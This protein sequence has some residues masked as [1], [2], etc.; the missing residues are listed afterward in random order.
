[1]LGLLQGWLAGVG[2]DATGGRLAVVTRGAVSAVAGE[3]VTDLAGAAVW[4]LVRSVQSEN[5]GRLVLADLPPGGGDADEDGLLTAALTAALTADEHELALR[6]GRVYARRLARPASPTSPTSPTSPGARDGRV[7]GTV[8]V[9][10][11]TGVLGG[12]VAGHLA[13][14][15][16]AR[17]LMLA[18]R[19]GPGAPGAAGL[20]AKLAGQGAAVRL[21]ACDAADRDALAGLLARVPAATPL[22]GVVHAAGVLDDGVTGSLTP[23]R[24]DAVMRPKADAAWH[25]HE[26]TQDANL[27]AFVLFSA[28]A[29]T[30][31]AAGQGNYAAAN[32]FLDGL[33]VRRHAEGRPAVSLAWGLWADAS[34]M[35]GH[36]GAAGRD[37]MARGGVRALTARDGLALLDAALTRDEALLVPARLDLSGLGA[38]GRP[39]PALLRALVPRYAALT[40]PAAATGA[41]P[42][43]LRRKLTRLPGAERDR[44]LLDLVRAHV[45][46]VLGH[47]SP[48]VIEPGRAFSEIGFDSLTAVELR[49]R[50]HDATGL[51][52]PATLVFDYPTPAALAARLRSE[53]LGA[54]LLG[55]GLLG[56]DLL[57]AEPAGARRGA[58]TAAARAVDDDP[59]AV[60]AMGC[61]FPGGVRDP[62]GFWQF[63]AAGWD[64]VSWFPDDRGW[65]AQ[66]PS[67]DDLD[68][69]QSLY[70][71]VGGFVYDAAE[72]DAG[73]FG[74]S[75]REAMAMDPQQRLLLEVS[76]EALERAGMDPGSLGGSPTGVFV[77]AYFMGYGVGVPGLGT[78]LMTGTA[79]SVMSGRISYLLGLEGPAVTVDTACSSSLV[80]LHLAC[81]SLRSG[82]CD[83]A[84]AG[85][86]AVMAATTGFEGFAR[87]RGLAADGRSK[88]FSAAADGMGLGEGAAMVVL[89]RLSDARRN[90]HPVLAV[91]AGSAVNQDGA[92]NGLTAPNGPSQQRV[93]RAALA[94]A[95]LSADQV[96]AV[97]A[98][99]TG[100]TLG[101][102]IEAQALIATY[103]QGRPADRPV[104]LGSVKSNIG[105]T[106]AAAGIA[107]VVKMVLA[108]RHG[109]LPATLYADEPSPHVDWAAGEVRLLTEPVPWPAGGDRPRRA[110]VSSFGFSGTNAHLIVQEAPVHPCDTAAP[111][112]AGPVLPG[113]LAWLVS[114]RTAAGLAAQADRLAGWVADRPDLDPADVGWSLAT[115]R[116]AFEHRAVVTGADRE[117]LAAGLAALAAGEPA[118]GL[119]TGAAPAGGQPRTVFVFPGQGGQWAGMGRDLAGCCPVFAARLA[120]CGRALAPFTGWDL[121]QV[122]AADVLPD[123]VDVVQPALWAVMVS[124]A[125]AWRAAGV[126]PDAVVGH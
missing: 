94:S 19:S 64:A 68:G 99:G 96:D 120:E 49:N 90:G 61:R 81:Q 102:P 89:E 65:E 72:F 50:L 31:G 30:F 20:A 59:V 38:S 22:T 104:W 43:T 85:G 23:E 26:L 10:G 76:W 28:A 84:L 114:G 82:E 14:T 108:L 16:R 93:I 2:P 92:S 63:L 126:V 34:A 56:A 115:T 67:G 116:S 15:G 80:A 100:T 110:G 119:I 112:H 60:V 66:S 51:R 12:L 98:H 29:A 42:E 95:G 86:A 21:V 83:L 113:A 97:E 52:L 117:E 53:L 5:P 48:E 70:T 39:V 11:G 75:P 103:G 6:D 47:A 91:V 105:H 4:G 55:A 111:E 40:R 27:D 79:S 45:A 35:T 8:L 3:N 78:H 41:G 13:A 7:A 74:I 62:Q 101:D 57:G 69:A 54:D 37:R 77:G 106:Q 118:P 9:T 36:L 1:M 17:V 32:A 109:L 121:E 122:L 24:V 125:A 88:A 87:Q 46:A 58:V 33:A 18:S 44:V 124:L 73:F 107:G 123:R 25:L 71:R